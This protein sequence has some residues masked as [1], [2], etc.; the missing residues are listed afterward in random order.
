MAFEHGNSLW[1][2]RS[3]HGRNPL[4]ADADTLWDACCQYFQWV[5]E[6][7]LQEAKPFA[8]Q[9]D[10]WIESVAKMRAMTIDGLQVFLDINRQTWTNYKNNDDFLAVCE[11]VEKIIREQKFVGAS[12]GLLN[13]SIIARDLG[14]ADKRE[15]SITVVSGDLGD[16]IGDLSED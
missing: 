4:F 2:A 8:F 13:P 10:S 9:G 12:A 5:D 1:R 14:L 3:T 15:Q 7:P 16:A 6:N 11:K